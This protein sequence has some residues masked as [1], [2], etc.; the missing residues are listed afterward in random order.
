[1][2]KPTHRMTRADLC[3]FLRPTL[4][5]TQRDELRARIASDLDAI[6]SLASEND[7]EAALWSNLIRHGLIEP[8]PR[9]ARSFLD[10]DGLRS[11]DAR[12]I[13]LMLEEAYEATVARSAQLLIQ[14]EGIIGVLN[15]AGIEPALL[16]GARWIFH[17]GYRDVASRSMVDIDL[18]LP[19]DQ[20]LDAVDALA[21]AG[22]GT[23]QDPLRDR[24]RRNTHLVPLQR[25]DRSAPVELHVELG[26]W[27]T[28]EM[29]PAEAVL[30][31]STSHV[32]NGSAGRLHVRH[33]SATHQVLHTILHSEIHHR[34]HQ[35]VEIPVR[36]LL[37]LAITNAT[38][39]AD[40]DW[41]RIRAAFGNRVHVLD[42][43]LH[44][45]DV[46]FGQSKPPG[47]KASPRARQHLERCIRRDGSPARLARTVSRLAAFPAALD[48]GRMTYLYG[49]RGFV[50]TNAARIRH[51][52]RMLRLTATRTGRA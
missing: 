38:S 35:A 17:D 49:S 13:A 9:S 47:F 28:P 39:D 41:T 52:A 21:G 5:G 51:V 6:A 26:D 12:P 43:L 46:L 15:A 2:P 16:K 29:L 11:T 27:P 25:P 10:G 37:D 4:T 8:V 3:S 34:G 23:A 1:M 44:Q 45:L 36:A 14:L 18:L 40:V 22:Y 42:S 19:P 32:L 20:A 50:G 33:L 24:S 7:T 30:S 31:E 48:T